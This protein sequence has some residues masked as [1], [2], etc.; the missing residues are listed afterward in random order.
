MKTL[1]LRLYVDDDTD[2]QALLKQIGDATQTTPEEM[3]DE[4][5]KDDA[6]SIARME[7]RA[8]VKDIVE[9]LKR[10]INSG[11]ITSEDEAQDWLR[12]TIDGHHD[13]IYTYAAMEVCRQSDNA[14]AYFD[15]FGPDGAVSESGIEWSK[16]AYCA[17]M[18]RGPEEIGD[19]AEL[20]DTAQ[21]ETE[22][23]E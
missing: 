20:I 14:Q 13:V 12:D 10:A 8:T 1:T 22:A 21:A 7:Y 17:L 4:R 16:L 23:A 18:P 15:V 3:T 5:I 9:D 2:T 19:V 6:N 11:E